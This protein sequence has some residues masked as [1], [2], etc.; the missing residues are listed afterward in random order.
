MGE[1]KKVSVVRDTYSKKLEET[2]LKLKAAAAKLAEYKRAEQRRIV[3]EANKATAKYY[4]EKRVLTSQKKQPMIDRSNE[5][6]DMS[7]LPEWRDYQK[8]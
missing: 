7:P 2:E 1:E 3:E 8:G 6:I 4:E 5:P